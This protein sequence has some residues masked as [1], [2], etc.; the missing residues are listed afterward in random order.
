MTIGALLIIIFGLLLFLFQFSLGPDRA[1]LE[2]ALPGMLWL[3]FVLAGLLG[4]GRS[5]LADWSRS[6]IVLLFFLSSS[7]AF[8][9]TTAFWSSSLI[10][11]INKGFEVNHSVAILNLS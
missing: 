8:L 6:L 4:L 7:P 11:C 1:R 3:G 9:V 5:F 2:S 10:E